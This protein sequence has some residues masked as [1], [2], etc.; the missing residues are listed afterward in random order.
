MS[1][2]QHRLTSP[3]Q[4]KKQL[5]TLVGKKINVVLKDGTT[6]MGELL[7]AE[8]E[9]IVL[10]NMRLRNVPFSFQQIAEVYFDTIV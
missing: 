2:R 5:E 7:K 1:T 10:R 9:Q 8:P 3:D 6:V 4:L